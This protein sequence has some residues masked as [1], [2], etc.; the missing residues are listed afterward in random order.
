MENDRGDSIS[1]N[2]EPRKYPFLQAAVHRIRRLTCGSC[3]SEY[4]RHLQRCV[5]LMWTGIFSHTTHV[6]NTLQ[7]S[8]PFI[9][10]CDNSDSK[11]WRS[12]PV[13]LVEHLGSTCDK[14]HVEMWCYSVLFTVYCSENWSWLTQQAS[15]LLP[16]LAFVSLHPLTPRKHSKL[17]LWTSIPAVMFYTEVSSI[18]YSAAD[19]S[20]RTFELHNLW[21]SVVV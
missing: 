8:Q 9:W 16:I 6:F 17:A 13:S 10:K 21:H 20:A 11:G 15:S 2:I 19:E 1:L 3:S 5:S 7:C 14:L 4:I 12:E 18:L